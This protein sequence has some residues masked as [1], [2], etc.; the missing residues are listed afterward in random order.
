MIKG[1]VAADVRVP[2]PAMLL[3]EVNTATGK[4]IIVVILQD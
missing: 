4:T 2:I 3:E 1:A